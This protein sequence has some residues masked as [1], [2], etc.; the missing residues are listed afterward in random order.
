MSKFD[1]KLTSS[2]VWGGDNSPNAASHAHV[3]T[4]KPKI[5]LNVETALGENLRAAYDNVLNEPVPD[6]FITLLD[7]LVKKAKS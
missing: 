6:R 5:D 1:D 7:N 2:I 3:G 4:Q